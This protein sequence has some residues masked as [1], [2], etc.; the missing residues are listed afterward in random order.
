MNET[1]L[2]AIL[3]TIARMPALLNTLSSILHNLTSELLELRSLVAELQPSEGKQTELA[4]VKAHVE[5]AL[6]QLMQDFNAHHGSIEEMVAPLLAAIDP[7]GGPEEKEKEKGK[8]ST[9]APT[10]GCGLPLEPKP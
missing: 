9:T 2:A 6:D 8:K 4:L 1:E 5:S 7:I 3:A 10:R